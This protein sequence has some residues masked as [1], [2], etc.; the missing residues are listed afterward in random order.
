MP[1][2]LHIV[3]VNN[4]FHIWVKSFEEFYNHGKDMGLIPRESK[5]W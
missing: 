1:H 4:E 3:E 5:H 2:V